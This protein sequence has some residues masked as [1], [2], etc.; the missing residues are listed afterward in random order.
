MDPLESLVDLPAN[1]LGAFVPPWSSSTFRLYSVRPFAPCEITTKRQ[2][3]SRQSHAVQY[4]TWT[5]VQKDPATFKH[6][7]P[8]MQ[9]NFVLVIAVCATFVVAPLAVSAAPITVPAGLNPGDHYRLAFMT[10]TSTHASSSDIADYNAFVS[11]VAS[12]V[13]ELA[14]LP[15]SWHAI[16]ST[17]AVAAKDN[18][19]TNPSVSIGD[20]IYNLGGVLVA[21]TNLA[22][23]SASTNNLSGPINTDEHGTSRTSAVFTGTQVDGSIATSHLGLSAG[24]LASTGA[25]SATNVEWIAFSS[26]NNTVSRPLYAMSGVLTVVPEPSTI[27]LLAGFAIGNLLACGWRRRKRVA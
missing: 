5:V 9:R 1:A 11:L 23:W 10:S 20:P 14:S 21:S 2:L 18:T 26:T 22:L 4:S 19:T 3:L 7:G 17:G 24:S 8:I 15:T 16:A 13:P 6:R 25:S 27:V 12:S